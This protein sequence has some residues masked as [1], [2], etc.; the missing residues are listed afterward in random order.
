VAST[1]AHELF[2][3]YHRGVFRYLTRMTGSRDV[4]ED[5]AQEVFLHVIRAQQNGGPIGHGRGWIF[6]IARN[7][8]IDHQRAVARRGPMVSVGAD[9]TAREGTQ[10]LAFSLGESLDQLGD[11]DREMFLLREMGGL[12]YEEIAK[13]CNCSVE[14]VRSRL[15]RTRCALRAMLER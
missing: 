2:A 9:S 1:S 5:L 11:A 15:H 14:A 7:L 13:L 6:S 10:A 3:Q 8:L 12:G 4:A